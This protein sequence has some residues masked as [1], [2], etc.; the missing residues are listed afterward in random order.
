[1]TYSAAILS[2]WFIAALFAG[3]VEYSTGLNQLFLIPYAG[4]FLLAVFAYQQRHVG[5]WRNSYALSRPKQVGWVPYQLLLWMILGVFSSVAALSSPLQVLISIKSY[6]LMWGVALVLFLRPYLKNRVQKLW[7]AVVIVAVAQWPIVLYQRLIIVPRRSDIAPWDAI[8]GSFGG[9]PDGG[10]NSAAMAMVACIAASIVA[11]RGFDR[12]ISRPKTIVL[13]FLCIGPS[14][15]AEVKMIFIWIGVLIVLGFVSMSR[16]SPIKAIMGLCLAIPLVLGMMFIYI[17]EFYDTDGQASLEQIYDQ[18]IK[19]AIDTEEFNE[20][21]QRLGRTAALAFWWDQNSN[22]PFHLIF[23]YGLGASKTTSSVS[24]GDI[25]Q[26]YPFEIDSSTASRLLWDTGI[27]GSLV[28]TLF[29]CSC[30][31]AAFRLARSRKLS[32]SDRLSSAIAG[33][34]FLLSFIGFSYN[35]DATDN[36]PIQTLLAVSFGVILVIRKYGF[37]EEKSSINN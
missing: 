5:L 18:Q 26:K 19:Y 12:R 28:F 3:I 24:Q 35:R 8:V 33:I 16:S 34:I 9:S 2:C 14:L 22:D 4:G 15:L 27:L 21:K 17:S 7:T 32:Q 20:G 25:A 23:G 30:I 11:L 31:A 1:M 29:F 36:A 37:S 10:G 6:F 13:I